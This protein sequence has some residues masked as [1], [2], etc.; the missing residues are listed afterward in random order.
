MLLQ[1]MDQIIGEPELLVRLSRA[2]GTEVE[3]YR[4]N[5]TPLNMVHS[6]VPEIFIVSNIPPVVR[7][8]PRRPDPPLT[9]DGKLPTRFP[10]RRGWHTDQSYRRPP[11]DIS[12]FMAVSPVRR[13]QG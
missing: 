9:E 12:L 2:I 4:R 5:L 3:D 13:D 10:H 7:M 6:T 1:G 11:P 8:P